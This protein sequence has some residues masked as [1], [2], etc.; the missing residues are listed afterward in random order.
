[1]YLSQVRKIRIIGWLVVGLSCLFMLHYFGF[2]STGMSTRQADEGADVEKAVRPRTGDGMAYDAVRPVKDGA[3]QPDVDNGDNAALDG[4][5]AHDSVGLDEPLDP[6]MFDTTLTPNEQNL[7]IPL[8][9]DGEPEFPPSY[10]DSPLRNVGGFIDA[11]EVAD[12][13]LVPSDE[14]EA[15]NTGEYLDPDGLE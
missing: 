13:G 1:M 8:D 2:S 3:T 4:I 10:E 6:E 11:D 12:S 5:P 9:I 7:G 15:V 14:S